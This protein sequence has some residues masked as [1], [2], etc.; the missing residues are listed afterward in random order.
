MPERS[1]FSLTVD[2]V[3]WEKV[4]VMTVLGEWWGSEDLWVS[5]VVWLMRGSWAC[6][7]LLCMRVSHVTSDSSREFPVSCLSSSPQMD[8]PAPPPPNPWTMAGLTSWL[9]K[10]AVCCSGTEPGVWTQELTNMRQGQARISPQ[11][12]SRH[13]RSGHTKLV[14]TAKSE[15][16]L[17]LS[18]FCDEIQG[19]RKLPSGPRVS[20]SNVVGFQGQTWS[21]A[22]REN[23]H[24]AGT[25]WQG[26]PPCAVLQE[27]ASETG[28]GY[29]FTDVLLPK[30]ICRKVKLYLPVLQFRTLWKAA[31]LIP[32]FYLTLGWWVVIVSH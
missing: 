9:I 31:E 25:A 28:R 24:G 15:W 23:W 14:A 7:L 1:C 26:P 13:I 19:Y 10:G 6:V 16:V 8:Q 22:V 21:A 11:A 17:V 30:Y 20:G 29:G 3:S 5:A 32:A 4:Y 18:A 2:C 12:K 27:G